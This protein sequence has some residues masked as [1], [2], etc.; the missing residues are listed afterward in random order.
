[1]KLRNFESFAS[2][3]LHTIGTHPIRTCHSH[4]DSWTKVGACWR[5]TALTHPGT[6]WEKLG[7]LSD[8]GGN[9]D[10]RMV[11]SM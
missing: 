10:L 3:L 6:H 4:G 7:W 2:A 11:T 1:M 8:E 5:S 9:C